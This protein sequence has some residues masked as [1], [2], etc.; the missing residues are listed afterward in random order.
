MTDITKD[1]I[2]NLRE[3]GNVML[4]IILVLFG[5]IL[6]AV[7]IGEIRYIWLKKHKDR[8]RKKI[9]EFGTWKDSIDKDIP[10]NGPNFINRF[11]IN[12]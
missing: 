5:I 7:F 11:K 3:G 10:Y 6:L 1:T 9:Q 4:S 12:P 8:K 2:L